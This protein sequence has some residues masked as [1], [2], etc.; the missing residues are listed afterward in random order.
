MG[1]KEIFELHQEVR[2]VKAKR[3]KEKKGKEK[4]HLS[5]KIL[6]YHTSY[7][8]EQVSQE[9]QEEGEKK[10]HAMVNEIMLRDGVTEIEAKKMIKDDYKKNPYPVKY[11]KLGKGEIFNYVPLGTMGCDLTLNIDH[12]F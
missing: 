6:Q 9:N 1:H 11:E 7:R 2:A 10:W 4:Q 8:P 5:E 3:E 12:P